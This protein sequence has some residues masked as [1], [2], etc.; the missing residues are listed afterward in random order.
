LQ[1]IGDSYFIVSELENS[2]KTLRAVKQT[3]KNAVLQAYFCW[4]GASGTGW[5][6]LPR[7]GIND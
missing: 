6:R 5:Q 2:T 7:V 4:M 3:H 1:Y